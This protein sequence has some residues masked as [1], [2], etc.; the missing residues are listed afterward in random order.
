MK[1]SLSRR[2]RSRSTTNSTTLELETD[3]A[4]SFIRG[5]RQVE[6]PS[7]IYEKQ[8]LA[9]FEW[10][11]VNTVEFL[12]G[13]PDYDP[14]VTAKGYYFDT[15]EWKRVINF[16]VNECTYPEGTHTGLPFIPERW[17]SCI[18]ANLLCW[19]SEETDNRRYR[20]CFIYVP[21]KNGKTTAFGAA[22]GLYM[23]YCDPEQRS[24][25]FCC[26]A[27][28]DQASVVF[29]HMQYMIE[30]NPRLLG[31]LREQRVFR[32]TKHFEHVDGATFKVLSSVA[33]TKHGLSAN[34][35]YVDEVHAHPNSELIDVMLTS[36][37]SRPQAL[38]LYTTTADYDRPSVCNTLHDKAKAIAANRQ[39]EPTFLPVIY[40]A[41]PDDDYTKE[42]VW[43]KA[44][45]NYGI[46]IFPEYFQR[47]VR[48]AQANPLELNRFLRLHLNIKTK[49]ETAWIP[50]FVWAGS[51]PKEEEVQLLSVSDIKKWMLEHPYWSN[52]AF[53]Q[54]FTTVQTVDL[55]ISRFQLYWSWFIRKCD[56]LRDEECYAGFDNSRVDD[57]ASLV[58]WFPNQQ[59]MLHWGWCPAQSIYRRS[60]E[61]N[62]PYAMWWEAGLLNST[63]PLETIDDEAI[64]KTLLG[65]QNFSGILTHFG[66]IRELC[67]DR[68]ASY[69]VHKKIQEFGYPARAYPQTFAGM[70]EPCRKLEAFAIDK[71]LFHG[72]NPLLEWQITNVVIHQ[73]MNGEVRPSKQKSTNKID[74][75]IAGLMAMG[76]WMYPETETISDIRGLKK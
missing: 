60:T 26:A 71:Q 43:R 15:E 53:S 46:S 72:G 52:I 6:V 76:S 5:T 17:Q 59:T 55:Y 13:L 68:F 62:L 31:Q 34:F 14:F 21:R 2:A 49:T 40:E 1:S 74:G 19:K 75:I 25:N 61:Q 63:S 10:V 47:L 58:L 8:A 28:A 67:F 35:V 33:D 65:D 56:E 3:P 18:Y 29:R 27:D 16:I 51:N 9:G 41:Q 54:K 64:C 73:N 11:K 48:N 45:P 50:A 44:N 12:R 32:A 42:V 70:N 30:N 4:E 38:I 39:W 7:P 20:E 24:Q 22:I 66:G 69:T 36:T 57:L 23:H 37:A